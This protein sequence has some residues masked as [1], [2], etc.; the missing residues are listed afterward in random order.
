M[1][2]WKKTIAISAS[3]LVATGVLAADH[4]DGRKAEH[5]AAMKAQLEERFK[6]LDKNGNDVVTHQE[7]M[8]KAQEKFAEFDK[9]RDGY[10]TLDELPKEM[11]VPEHIKERM[12]KRAERVK[13]G[14]AER[15]DE[16]GADDMPPPPQG[17]FDG[18]PTRLKF[19]AKHDKDGDER[20]SLDEF[21]RKPI[22]HFK[23]MD[24]D[25]NGEVTKAEAFEAAKEHRKKRGKGHRMQP[26]HSRWP[27]NTPP[28]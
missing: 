15:T 13:A 26:H 14:R 28:E 17:H 1:K 19:L 2:V 27:V 7:M 11:P 10:L 3:A 23:R 22:H 18:K 20:V 24:V 21:A 25:G 5:I 4:M 12:E 9:N 8:A 16:R 6:D